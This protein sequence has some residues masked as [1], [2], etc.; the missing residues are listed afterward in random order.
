MVSSCFTEMSPRVFLT[1]DTSNECLY[2]P[3]SNYKSCISKGFVF[4]KMFILKEFFHF[5]FKPKCLA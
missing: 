5:I 1:T 2:F 3:L 4:K